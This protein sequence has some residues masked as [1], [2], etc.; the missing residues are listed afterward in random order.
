MT[1]EIC[2]KG[3]EGPSIFLTL[4]MGLKKRKVKNHC[5]RLSAKMVE[6]LLFL[7]CYEHAVSVIDC[8]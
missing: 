2:V 6:T 3:F 7:K 5:S 1:L 8:M 4:R